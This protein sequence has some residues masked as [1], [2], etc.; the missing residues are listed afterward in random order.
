MF[1]GIIKN[2]GLIESID[3]QD[4]VTRVVVSVDEVLSDLS[5]GDSVAVNGTCLT[6]VDFDDSRLY[7]DVISETLDRTILGQ[8]SS[9]D[10]V[11]VEYSMR[12][13]DF[14][15]GHLVSGHVD[16][17]SELVEI[18]EN[19]YWFRL[20]SEYSKYVVVKGS[21]VV[22]GVSLTVNKIDDDRFRVDLIP[23]T[24]SETNLGDLDVSSKVNIEIDLIAR[25]LEKLV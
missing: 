3:S 10:K 7:F 12:L 13:N 18:D 19:Q 15:G 24:L 23:E 1:T 16:F 20:D 25:Y 17:V 5:K 2:L 6:V 11:N 21:I 9:G 4:S 14:V 8:L 22:N